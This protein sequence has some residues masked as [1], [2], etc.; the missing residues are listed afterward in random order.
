[1]TV[2]SSARAAKDFLAEKVAEQAT[3]ENVPFRDDERR[4]MYYSVDDPTTQDSAESSD[5]DPEFE[6]KISGLIDRA[7]KNDSDKSRYKAAFKKLSEGDHYLSV[8]NPF[9]HRYG[10]G[11]SKTEW[12]PNPFYWATG[13]YPF[14][15]SVKATPLRKSG[16]LFVTALALATFMAL[17]LGYWEP[18]K[19]SFWR[20]FHQV[21]GK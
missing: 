21:A 7:Y 8:M 19:E 9:S 3:L 16:K 2:F 11:S 13:R 18:V 15:P 17:L 4:L 12:Y 6:A 14:I 10:T 1:M 20:W 5:A